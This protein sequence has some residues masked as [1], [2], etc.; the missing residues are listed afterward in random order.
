MRVFV[1]GG[2]GAIGTPLVRQLVERGHQVTATTRRPDR[3]GHLRRIGATV[4]IMDGLDAASVGEAVARAE[5]EAI[6]H[7]MTAL[8]GPPDMRHFDRWFRATNALRTTGTRHLLA[9]GQAVGVKQVSDRIWLVTFMDYD[10]GYFD[11]ETC[12]PEPIE[13]P[14]GPKVLAM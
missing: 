8:S 14:F 1:A 11:D 10:L 9:A 6:I 2:T 12:R 7:Q 5:P 4:A 3:A 13:N